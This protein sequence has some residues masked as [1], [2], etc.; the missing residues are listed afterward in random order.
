MTA[1]AV[2]AN[3]Q[4]EVTVS[5]DVDVEDHAIPAVLPPSFLQPPSKLIRT[6][7]SRDNTIKENDRRQP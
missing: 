7:A 5:D 3:D 2:L 6:I 4:P 1:G